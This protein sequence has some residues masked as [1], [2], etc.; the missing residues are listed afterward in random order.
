[1]TETFFKIFFPAEGRLSETV[2]CKDK[3]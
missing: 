1:M 3:V 2:L